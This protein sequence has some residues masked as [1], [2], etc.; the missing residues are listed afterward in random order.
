VRGEQFV[1][2]SDTGGVPSLMAK[3]RCSGGAR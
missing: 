3:F 1:R 2:M